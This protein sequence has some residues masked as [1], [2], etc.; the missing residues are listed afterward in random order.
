M[1]MRE[2][3]GSLRAYFLFAGV[4]SLLSSIVGVQ[5]TL[6][7]SRLYP[8]RWE[9]VLWFAYVNGLAFGLGFLHAGVRLRPTLATGAAWIQR[10]LQLLIALVALGLLAALVTGFPLRGAGYGFV[11][12]RILISLYLLVNVRRLAA[13][14]M[15]ERERELPPAR[16]V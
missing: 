3:V 4:I 13:Q 1:A 15:K 16:V 2:T 12:G 10:M 5:H 9:L 11:L 14:V 8:L 6:Q 7:L